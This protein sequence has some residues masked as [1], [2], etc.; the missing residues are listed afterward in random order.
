MG[1]VHMILRVSTG[2]HT[3]LCRQTQTDR[4]TD[5]PE[6]DGVEDHQQD[7]TPGP[8]GSG[9]QP[10]DGSQALRGSGDGH[11][12]PRGA[13]LTPELC[14]PSQMFYDEHF[15]AIIID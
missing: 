15:I 5:P 14:V 11:V 13:I 4:L 7:H 8:Q 9:E 6:G 10:C 1:K 3:V 2:Q 12:N